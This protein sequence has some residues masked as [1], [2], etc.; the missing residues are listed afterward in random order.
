VGNLAASKLIDRFHHLPNLSCIVATI[1]AG[2]ACTCFAVLGQ[3]HS[4]VLV[5]IASAFFGLAESALFLTMSVCLFFIWFHLT[6]RKLQNFFAA[7]YGGPDLARIVSI[8]N[9][10]YTVAVAVGPSFFAL[11]WSETWGFRLAFAT[12]AI[13]CVIE[14]I[15]LAISSTRK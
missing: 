11:L 10:C 7:V 8:S 5:V 15:F 12:L 4:F 14:T 1:T 13:L 3:V 9:G 6:V 2:L